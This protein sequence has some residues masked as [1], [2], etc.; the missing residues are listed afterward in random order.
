MASGAAEGRNCFSV[1]SVDFT[2]AFTQQQCPYCRAPLHVHE[3]VN[4][5]WFEEV[6]V[7]VENLQ[8]MANKSS[9]ISNLND[10]DL[11]PTH[12]EEK[13]S[14]YCWTCKICICHKCA[15]WGGESTR[16]D[17]SRS[18]LQF[19]HP[20]ELTQITPSSNWSWFTR[21]ICRK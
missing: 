7:Q 18:R 17:Q 8:I 1:I 4:C 14:V 10:K 9:V 16:S 21:R 20:Q 15:L 13:L 11:C 5:R 3:L 12:N 19:L 6:A 2:L